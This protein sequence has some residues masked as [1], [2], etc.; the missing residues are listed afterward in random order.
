VR[1]TTGGA[2]EVVDLDNADHSRSLGWF[3]QVE[4]LDLGFVHEVDLHASILENDV[5]RERLCLSNGAS[6][7]V[8]AVQVNR[9][10][11]GAKVKRN[12]FK[13]AGSLEGL[14]QNMLTGMLFG[15]VKAPSTVDLPGHRGANWRWITGDDVDDRVF[16]VD[17]L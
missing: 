6:I 9:A 11:I 4:S 5:V 16:L 8:S 12:R 15:V 14:R 17:D 3:A 13:P 2:V 10:G 7:D 1:A